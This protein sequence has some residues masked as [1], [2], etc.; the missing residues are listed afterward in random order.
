MDVRCPL[1]PVLLPVRTYGTP[2]MAFDACRDACFSAQRRLPVFSAF[3]QRPASLY[4]PMLYFYA[5][6][7][8]HRIFPSACGSSIVAG[9]SHAAARS[10]E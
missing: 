4:A 3:A 8:T 5:A 10:V 6:G 1:L 7:R 2:I 9:A